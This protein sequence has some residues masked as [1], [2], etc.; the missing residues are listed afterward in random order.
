[1]FMSNDGIILVNKK[2]GFTSRDV[3]NKACKILNTK[4]VGHCGTLDPFATGLLILAVNKGTKLLQFMDDSNKVYVAKMKLGILTDTLDITGTIIKNEKIKSF[5][6]DELVKTIHSFIGKQMQKTPMYSARKINGKKLYE[7]A[8]NNEKVED[9][10]KEIEIYSIELID[11]YDD[12]VVFICNVSK[13]T[14]VRQLAFD[15]AEKLGNIAVLEELKRIS[16]GNYSI[17]NAVEIDDISYDK[18]IDYNNVL[19]N[20]PVYKVDNELKT[21]VINGCSI[22]IVSSEKTLLLKDYNNN[23]LAVYEKSGSLYKCKRMLF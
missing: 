1:M 18:V 17:N 23:I 19:D 21:K 14:Y 9:I 22:N 11:Y 20:I 8:R 4:K 3:V 6:K 2:E 10:Y 15:I 5:T 16:I 7:Y 13:G 12:N